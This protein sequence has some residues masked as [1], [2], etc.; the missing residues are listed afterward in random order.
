MIT[1]LLVCV[2]EGGG[3]VGR[4]IMP[5]QPKFA[6]YIPVELVTRDSPN[7]IFKGQSSPGADLG[8]LM[9][10]DCKLNYT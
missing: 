9:W 8:I 4:H 3:G 10:W 7:H 2:W 6:S 1:E 5:D